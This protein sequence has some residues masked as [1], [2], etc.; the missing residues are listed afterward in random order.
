M[1]TSHVNLSIS[2]DKLAKL[3]H[4]GELC[5]ADFRCLDHE[6]K[7]TVWQLCLLCC[8][9][10]VGCLNPCSTPCSQSTNFVTQPDSNTSIEQVDE[11]TSSGN[12]ITNII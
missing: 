9:K 1:R 11:I 12:K 2:A 7:Q 8:S 5:A 3:I 10:R 6:S 4:S